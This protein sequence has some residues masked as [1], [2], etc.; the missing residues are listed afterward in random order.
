MKKRGWRIDVDGYFGPASEKVARQFQA[1]K[2]IR[3]DGAVGAQT[4]AASWSEP[5]T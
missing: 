2:G 1:E 5:V 3:V 4:W